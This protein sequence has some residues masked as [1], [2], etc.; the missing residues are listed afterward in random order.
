MRFRL[1]SLASLVP[2]LLLLN[3]CGNSTATAPSDAG[4]AD[5]TA[6]HADGAS[7]ED[8][9][10]ADAAG[11]SDGG[12][13]DAARSVFASITVDPT[14]TLGTI[15]PGFVGLS[16]E[17]SHL[18]GGFFRGDNAALVAMVGLLGP[19]V[20][21]VGGNSVDAT[22][23]QTFDAGA[24]SGDA[25]A[26]TYITSA[27]VDGLAAFAKAARWTVLYG[28]NL[29]T[30]SS[31][32]DS[33]EAA[34]AA[35]ALGSAL[36]G[37]EIGN[38]C[39]LY[40]AVASSPGAWSYT[41]FTKDWGAFESA[42]HASAPSAPFTGPASASHY[43]SWT[44]PFAKD[45]A[46]KIILLTQHYYVANGQDPTS[47]IDLLLSPNPGLVTELQALST[48]A[49]GNAIKNL[50]RLSECNSFYNG[51]ASGVSNAYGTALWAIDFLFTNAQYGSA[52][53]NFHGGGNGTGYTPIADANG[54]VGGARP[55]FYGMLLFTKA[56]QGAILATS[57]APSSV[58]FSAYAVGAA[59]SAT[60]VVL[61]NKDGVTTVH[62]AVDVGAPLSSATATRLTG[63]AL[64][65][66][67]G[68]TLGGVAIGADGSFTPNAPEALPTAGSTF[69]VDVPPASAVLVA[70]K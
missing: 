35:T 36:Y 57:G 50:Y 70:V 46:S 20:L 31:A 54:S 5:A 48:A 49:T 64:D 19:S 58:N 68:V 44:V 30:S 10:V 37:F 12:P 1:R 59:G 38:E 55:I 69:T 25:A 42:I 29:K 66:T 60:S 41:A 63:P 62:A 8:G 52:G 32:V 14:T 47:T 4:P 24:P 9:A 16:Y 40:T 28:V 39:D 67:T 23:W 33:S 56:G 53:V 18:T 11:E 43:A 17:K 13:D 6:S 7:S 2:F 51:G 34:Y 3:A 65:A 26:P 21:R 61:S 15:G 45:E 27:D 22:V